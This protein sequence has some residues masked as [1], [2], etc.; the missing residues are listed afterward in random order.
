MSSPTP[1]P[2]CAPCGDTPLAIGASVI[3]F[4]TYI[5]GVVAGLSYWYGLA[6]SNP[7]EI[8]RFIEELYLSLNEIKTSVV[9]IESVSGY[10]PGMEFFRDQD[11]DEISFRTKVELT[12]VLS[13]VEKQLC[14]PDDCTIRSLV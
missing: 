1:S 12:S 8:K 10:R 4:L 14:S 13:K 7:E 3:T 6:K 5:S 2:V 9:E 11:E